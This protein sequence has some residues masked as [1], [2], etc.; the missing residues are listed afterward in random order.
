MG[1]YTEPRISAMIETSYR[2]NVNTQAGELEGKWI[3]HGV[4]PAAS[5][6]LPKT[7]NT[8]LTE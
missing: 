6:R 5:L 1:L 3:S 8:T 4:R 2:Y 7:L